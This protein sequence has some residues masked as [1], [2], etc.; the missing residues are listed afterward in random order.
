MITSTNKILQKTKAR[1]VVVGKNIQ[2]FN[3]LYGQQQ[4]TKKKKKKKRERLGIVEEGGGRTVF[5]ISF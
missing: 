3:I 4:T 5:G 2:E 1:R